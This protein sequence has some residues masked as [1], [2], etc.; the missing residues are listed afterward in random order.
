MRLCSE[1]HAPLGEHEYSEDPWMTFATVR[2]REDGPDQDS[3]TQAEKV[4]VLR[5]RH[6]LFRH[7]T[8]NCL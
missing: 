2:T 6:I 5:K 8:L 1:Q 7:K 3:D 4:K